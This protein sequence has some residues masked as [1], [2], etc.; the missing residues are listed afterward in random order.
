MS[1]APR[2]RTLVLTAALA[3]VPAAAAAEPIE[4]A[5]EI[6]VDF[7]PHAATLSVRRSVRSDAADT[8]EA[9][10]AVESAFPLVATGL[11]TRG[12]DGRWYAATLR[13]VDQAIATYWMLT[14]SQKVAPER[15]TG[16]RFPE[17]RPR[18]PALMMWSDTGV[19]IYVFPVSAG[20]PRTVEYTLVLT[21]DHSEGGR[22]VHVPVGPDALPPVV[23]VGTVPAGHR[24]EHD[25]AGLRTG[26]EII[27]SA[28]DDLVL[29]LLP[30]TNVPLAARLAVT[31]AGAR[32]MFRV[33]V[34][35]GALLGPDPTDT[36]AVI[37][38][39]R[40]RSMTEEGHD[41]ARQAARGYLAAL[42]RVPGARV[43]VVEFA[44]AARRVHGGFVTPAE[45]AAALADAQSLTNGSEL[46]S[47]LELTRTIVEQAPR[48]APRRVLVLSDSALDPSLDEPSRRAL[49]AL[50]SSR[51]IV[52]L[53]A[54]RADDHALLQVDGAHRFHDAVT[55]T[56][57]L[58]WDAR[59][60]VVHSDGNTTFVE[61]VRPQVIRDLEIAVDDAVLAEAFDLAAGEGAAEID[62]L[63]HAPRRVT[64]H[65]SLWS[66]PIAVTARRDAGFDRA[67]TVL[68]AAYADDRLS[69][70]ELVDVAT[71]AG[72]VSPKTAYLALEPG[73]KPGQALPSPP[74]PRRSRSTQCGLR[75]G[76]PF[77]RVELTFD[78]PG[79]IRAAVADAA[80][81]CR[82][83][84]REVVAHL[85]TTYAEVVAV[86][87]VEVEGDETAAACV[88]E[89]LWALEF[90][91]GR[92]VAR[93][94]V[95]T[96][97]P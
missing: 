47:A 73:A 26:S 58:V 77:G 13:P 41:A 25:G 33:E 21:Y 96:L 91:P 32:H 87:K 23:R 63:A 84:A 76:H 62:L 38:L 94:H 28:G 16:E 24:V 89:R 45:A 74:S 51:A 7:G 50:Q 5:H 88:R 64:A 11:R 95:V 52:H 17:L 34:D 66:T 81:R 97:A 42:A 36:H 30:P 86:P 9:R 15:P 71:R 31:R 60:D 20:S 1:P 85:T 18:D 93:G 67:W 35:S 83:G 65:G 57:G 46:A 80:R 8:Y 92:D 78:E 3:A 6:L 22:A 53:P 12:D 10:L 75:A 44:R 59:A 27:K 82:V 48:S 39:D 69:D 68:A 72:A 4:A 19:E 2:A 43:E 49:A 40:S 61:W 37:V 54:T 29:R 90:P 55:A 79:F 70:A 56:G 14:G